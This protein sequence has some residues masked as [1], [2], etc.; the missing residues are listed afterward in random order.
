MVKNSISRIAPIN[1]RSL[2]RKVNREEKAID[3]L[4]KL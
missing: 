2:P 1:G 4:Y 3:R